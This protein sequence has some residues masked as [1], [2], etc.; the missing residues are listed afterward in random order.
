MAL[1]ARFNIAPQ[2]SCDAFAKFAVLR[3]YLIAA[4]FCEPAKE[5][6]P[7]F[8]SSPLFI[9]KIVTLGKHRQCQRMSRLCGSRLSR[10]R[11]ERRQAA[12]FF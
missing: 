6:C 9:L 3:H 5:G 10:P 7:G 12:A 4:A 11:A 2:Y 1:P 8:E